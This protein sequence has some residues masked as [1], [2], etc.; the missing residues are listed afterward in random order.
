LAPLGNIFFFRLPPR[1]FPDV[2]GKRVFLRPLLPAGFLV[3]FAAP[4]PVRVCFRLTPLLRPS[5]NSSA[6]S[7][8]SFLFFDLPRGRSNS[9]KRRPL[10]SL[11]ASFF[12]TSTLGTVVSSLADC[13]S[14]LHPS[15]SPVPLWSWFFPKHT[16][17]FFPSGVWGGLFLNPPF[18]SRKLSTFLTPPLGQR[19]VLFTSPDQ[20]SLWRF[21][22]QV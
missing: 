15:P 5:H 12:A 11:A 2:F 7:F 13:F 6:S 19:N 3:C 10:G 21:F 14:F 17:Q 16:L 22:R 9:S 1:G 8:P 18:S 4:P 20:H